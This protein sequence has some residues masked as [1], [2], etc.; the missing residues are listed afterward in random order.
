MPR[1]SP[2]SPWVPSWRPRVQS[3]TLSLVLALSC[4]GAGCAGPAAE[5]EA[6]LEAGHN[7]E[8]VQRLRAASRER[9]DDPHLHAVLGVALRRSGELD[10]AEAE[11]RR[12]L[13]LDPGE[14]RALRE[15]LAL[16]LQR[17]RPSA[18]LSVAKALA[19]RAPD[20]PAVA[21]AAHLALLEAVAH[22]ALDGKRL[23]LAVEVLEEL[24]QLQPE[25]RAELAPLLAQA[26]EGRA[27][28]LAE[29][30][31]GGEA[32][33]EIDAA[34]AQAGELGPLLRQRALLLLGLD[35][36]AE[37]AAA[38]E[39]W[40]AVAP[41]AAEAGRAAAMSLRQGERPAEAAA[42]LQRAVDLP[43]AAARPQDLLVLAEL[44]L[45][46]GQ[47]ARA[48]KAL[49]RFIERKGE[50]VAG[51]S[52]AAELAEGAGQP[53]LARSFRAQA[54]AAAPTDFEVLRPYL[55][56]LL[57]GGRREEALAAVA[58]YRRQ[59]PPLEAHFLA[60]Q[61]YQAHGEPKAAV[62]AYEHALRV[63]PS[64]SVVLLRLAEI[65]RE[66]GDAAARRSALQRFVSRAPDR[67]AALRKVAGIYADSGEIDVAL[68]QLD[69]AQALQ[70][71]DASL[72]M[73]RARILEQARRPAQEEA[74][75]RAYVARS[76]HRAEAAREVALR[77]QSRS[78]L[79]RATA[80]LELG[81][82]RAPARDER[83]ELLLLR[84]EV[85]RR[86]DD[87][88]ALQQVL[89]RLTLEASGPEEESGLLRKALRTVAPA[90]DAR[91]ELSLLERLVAL[92]PEDPELRLQQGERHL[93][94]GSWAS[95]RAAFERYEALAPDR[96]DAL[97]HV[98]QAYGRRRRSDLALETL[99]RL[100][101]LG[102]DD[103]ARLLEAVELRLEHGSVDDARSRSLLLRLLSGPLPEE[104]QVLSLARRLHEQRL[105]PEAELAYRRAE[106]RHALSP[107]DLMALARVLLAQRK[108][109]DALAILHRL[110][111]RS[112]G[113]AR[114][115]ARLE[116]GQAASDVGAPRLALAAYRKVLL[117]G[118]GP[119]H[120]A[121]A[122][123][124]DALRQSGA[125]DELSR[126]AALYAQHA[127]PAE[128][129][130]A[131]IA[132]AWEI[133]GDDARALQAWQSVLAHDPRSREALEQAAALLLRQGRGGEAVRL[134]ERQVEGAAAPGEAWLEVAARYQRWGAYEEALAFYGRAEAAGA[135]KATLLLQRARLLLSLGRRAEGKE[136]ADAA[137]ALLQGEAQQ[138]AMVDLGQHYVAVGWDEE[139]VAVFQRALALDRSNHRFYA[140]L[141]EL[142]LRA[143]QVDAARR[144]L[145]S[146]RAQGMGRLLAV[147]LSF[148]E[149]G[150]SG[151]ARAIYLQILEDGIE[152][153][154]APAFWRLGVELVD[155]G[156]VDDLAPLAERFLGASAG[157]WEA[158]WLVS[159][160][161]ARAG[162][163]RTA[164][165]QLQAGAER[166]DAPRRW[167]LVAEAALRAGERQVA[168]EALLRQLAAAEE[169]REPLLRDVFRLLEWRREDGL[170]R[171]LLELLRGNVLDEAQYR[172]GRAR[173]VLG[174]GDLW[175]GS[176]GLRAALSAA[177][178]QQQ[179]ALR[180]EA[181]EAMADA[182]LALEAE[183]VLLGGEP[184]ESLGKDG[185]L[186]LLQ[187]RAERAEG[188][189]GEAALAAARDAYLAAAPVDEAGDR[190]SA[191]ATLRGAGR[192]AGAEELLR[193]ALAL[194]SGPEQRRLALYHLL[195][196]L[197]GLGKEEE[198]RQVARSYVG[199]S[200][201][202]LSAL[203]SAVGELGKLQRW[204]IAR[205]LL[206]ERQLLVRGDANLVQDSI[207]VR[208][209][210]GEG[211]ALLEPV[212]DLLRQV[213]AN[214]ADERGRQDVLRRL[215]SKFSWALRSEP[216]LELLDELQGLAPAE[217][218][219]AERRVTVFL[220]RGDGAALRAEMERFLA[221][222][223]ERPATLRW[224]LRRC[225]TYGRGA[226][227]VDV[228][229]RLLAAAPQD[230]QAP[231][232][233]LAAALQAGDEARAQRFSTLALGDADAE[234][235]RRLLV[236]TLWLQG[237]YALPDVDEDG[238]WWTGGAVASRLATVEAL[239]GP[240][241]VAG[242]EGHVLG[243]LLRGVARLRRG[244]VRE[245]QA[246]LDA[247]VERGAGFSVGRL[248]AFPLADR[249]ELEVA[250]LAESLR[251]HPGRSAGAEARLL[252]VA[253]ALLA[254]G[255][256][257]AVQAL[258]P[259]LL[260]E[261]GL[262]EETLAR[263][264]RRAGQHRATALG[265]WLVDEL[266]RWEPD[267]VFQ[268][269]QLAEFLEQGGKPDLAV[270][271][272]RAALARE[273]YQ[274]V[275][276]NNLAYLF[277]RRGESLE[278]ALGLAQQALRLGPQSARY[279]LDTEGWVLHGLGRDEE[280]RA[281]IERSLWVMDKS[282]G[283]AV[284]ESFVHL[285]VV[286]RALGR[287]EEAR[288]AFER[289]SAL[290]LWGEYGERARAA[291][292]EQGGATPG[293]PE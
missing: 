34:L 82:E 209:A 44:W 122:L 213:F 129:V 93:E 73:E 2:R 31:R 267:S 282:V 74:A 179:P 135:P 104:L 9:G 281:R 4:G 261:S 262:P 203:H 228:A 132:R 55:D 183:Q 264:L 241:C 39:R 134:V 293:T 14:L 125:A 32:L 131:A 286:L 26:H 234:P 119:Q 166:S 17:E 75:W 29:E 151:Q 185:L 112:S 211:A 174:Q 70:P 57:Q 42:F 258:V 249:E 49:E 176:R 35:R 260:R 278:E 23:G 277:A 229:E 215:A 145:A 235:L 133:F 45:S 79:D 8:A 3:L 188:A 141:A 219:P 69:E 202:P 124:V 56:L 76:E 58:A 210:L 48:R 37:A 95:G 271:V 7:T 255:Q 109:K 130:Q 207:E 276:S 180:A 113:V 175:G 233:A 177:S 257:A 155:A 217:F 208:L 110:E 247:V 142:H 212:R 103:P 182:G 279:Y 15:L 159:L 173:L 186:L 77:Y 86:R 91:L 204:E 40:V 99:D 13:Q 67:V 224:L 254:A 170:A 164:L 153:Q 89:Q 240:L 290:D 171:E 289:A 10:E 144:V 111:E 192:L 1:S 280:A 147:G 98:A 5:G 60:G 100:I 83:Q 121:F 227:A 225:L 127:G 190:I 285:G 172:M 16:L 231:L 206:D 157:T 52:Q 120:Q 137:F 28:Q 272:Y 97:A 18:A 106:E 85:Q 126:L 205:Q 146:A 101:E 218:A 59:A 288:A 71:K 246:D 250:R 200:P 143:G 12:A 256:E 187:L 266:G 88:D 117:A 273:P 270:Q 184:L 27:L 167:L 36:G 263:L 138:R 287:K 220:D 65:H 161:Y 226:A 30:G 194:A 22:E 61:W 214:P 191:G 68:K 162:R 201:A 94:L 156:R 223:G 163:L 20:D 150:Q 116:W 189:A 24:L 149:A 169:E 269:T 198:L 105:F 102:G 253:D 243:C 19:Q 221:K 284:S 248:E 238:R 158:H 178:V 87:R 165:Q 232:L 216:A 268:A 41:D 152:G 291:L 236:A 47:T 114:Q 275:Y 72:Q 197:H 21:P 230:A 239:A 265:L 118:E 140:I 245:G 237:G 181:A 43:G 38:F 108:E 244:Q 193:R 66:A 46:Q 136:A 107:A 160:L 242:P 25:R 96:L 168:L 123:A 92:Q 259:R 251:E 62:E 139:A 148:E 195:A 196:V 292:R 84:L 274:A 51:A 11:L 63:S 78:D 81:L 283:A 128:E 54:V 53:E 252:L 115:R 6:L 222:A 80:F 90:R 64:R 199:E 33:A 50:P 154:A